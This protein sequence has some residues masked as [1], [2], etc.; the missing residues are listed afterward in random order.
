MQIRISHRVYT[1]ARVCTHT[2]THFALL[3]IA[4]H[5]PSQL[6]FPVS[7]P[8]YVPIRFQLHTTLFFL[9][10]FLL[11]RQGNLPVFSQTVLHTSNHTVIA[12]LLIFISK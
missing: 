10:C 5:A 2:H 12:C 4:F 7:G 6:P 9:L 3:S 1:R 11:L 8:C